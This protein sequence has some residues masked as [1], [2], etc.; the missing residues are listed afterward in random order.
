MPG[1]SYTDSTDNH[2]QPSGSAELKKSG[3]K[4]VG[5]SSI[6]SRSGVIHQ[7]R[8]GRGGL[9][10]FFFSFALLLLCSPRVHVSSVR[11]EPFSS[12]SLPS[13][14]SRLP[15]SPGAKDVLLPFRRLSPPLHFP[16]YHSTVRVSGTTE[17][18]STEKHHLALPP[19]PPCAKPT[20]TTVVSCVYTYKVRA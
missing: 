9:A 3:D 17:D 7:A 6:P 1:S 20:K 10:P 13:P 15:H 12:S 4:K 8:D 2:G 14:P 5:P 19:P 18:A 16:R 11:K